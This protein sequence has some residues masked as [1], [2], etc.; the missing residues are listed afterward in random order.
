MLIFFL[1]LGLV[2]SEGDSTVLLVTPSIS[3]DYRVS[4]K[5]NP[6]EDIL[7]SVGARQSYL[8]GRHLHHTY[9]KDVG[10][11]NFTFEFLTNGSLSHAQTASSINQGMYIPGI[12]EM[13]SHSLMNKSIPP[14]EKKEYKDFQ[15]Y[16]KLLGDGAVIHYKKSSPVRAMYNETDTFFSAEMHCVVINKELGN[17]PVKCDESEKSKVACKEIKEFCNRDVINTGDVCSCLSLYKS[18]IANSKKLGDI[19]NE[20]VEFLNDTCE[21]HIKKVLT[22]HNQKLMTNKL[23]INI[24]E[25][26]NK[27]CFVKLY[28]ISELQMK[29]LL[30]I[31][32]QQYDKGLP[33]YGSMLSIKREPGAQKKITVHFNRNQIY[34]KGNENLVYNGFTNWVDE[35]VHKDYDKA[36]VSGPDPPGPDPDPDPDPDPPEPASDSNLVLIILLV[37]GIVV[38]AGLG[39]GGFFFYKRFRR[40]GVN[41]EEIEA[42]R[43]ARRKEFDRKAEERKGRGDES[44]PF[45]AGRIE[46]SGETDAFKSIMSKLDSR[47]AKKKGTKK[48]DEEISRINAGEILLKE[49]ES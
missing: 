25:D 23:L 36:C 48:E 4:S 19:A 5:E 35:G 11:C 2:S 29:A 10:P 21:D 41:S 24:K 27:D 42:E 15:E 13:L 34:I 7:S 40:S 31:M 44:E 32:G 1:I 6:F 47:K 39:V 26:L 43:E 14:L 38:L 45:I 33:K 8:I 12:G 46:D 22:Q 17:S 20:T 3:L 30:L 37:A 18:A 9:L 28:V 16:T 49:D